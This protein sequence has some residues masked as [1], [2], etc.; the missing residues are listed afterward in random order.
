MDK[1]EVYGKLDSDGTLKL[2]ASDI[3]GYDWIY[4]GVINNLPDKDNIK[5]IKIE[6]P[7]APNKITFGLLSNLESIENIS[8]LHTENITNMSNMFCKCTSLK[9]IDVNSFDTSRVLSM[10]GMFNMCESI[11]E[12]KA[13]NLDTSIVTDMA[14]MFQRMF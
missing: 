9:T 5:K 8:Y 12:I 10:A 1:T 3:G 7:I 11:T 6:E 4:E 13:D 14:N 2:K